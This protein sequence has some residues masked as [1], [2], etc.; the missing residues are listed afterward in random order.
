M[1][2]RRLQLIT[3]NFVDGVVV[4]KRDETEASSL[5]GVTILCDVDRRNRTELWEILSQMVL[6]HLFFYAS[7]KQLHT[8]QESS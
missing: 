8:H 7:D 1:N 2:I 4:I 3:D 6:C 5:A